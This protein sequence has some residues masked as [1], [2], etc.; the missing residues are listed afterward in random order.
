LNIGSQDALGFG[1]LNNHAQGGLVT[2]NTSKTLS[3]DK[4]N[5]VVG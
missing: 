5:I 1:G 2:S 4:S 3:D